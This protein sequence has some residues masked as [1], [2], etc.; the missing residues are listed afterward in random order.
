MSELGMSDRQ[1]LPP[2]W[3]SLPAGMSKKLTVVVAGIP[4]RK[5]PRLAP[6][7]LH[8]GEAMPGVGPDRIVFSAAGGGGTARHRQSARETARISSGDAGPVFKS[9]LRKRSAA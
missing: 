5:R 6:G 7:P 3:S 9:P 8:D 1:R 2:S 4:N